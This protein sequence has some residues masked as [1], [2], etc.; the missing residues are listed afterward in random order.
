P[1]CR[2][3]ASNAAYRPPTKNWPQKASLY[4]QPLQHK[5]NDRTKRGILLRQRRPPD[6]HILICIR[7]PLTVGWPDLIDTAPVIGAQKRAGFRFYHKIPILIKTQIP[8]DQ[9]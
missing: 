6:K 9:I 1:N 7:K 3:M 4:H 8:V 5:I 2:A